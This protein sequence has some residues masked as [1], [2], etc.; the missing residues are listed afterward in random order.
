MK[1]QTIPIPAPLCGIRFIILTDGT[2]YENS[3]YECRKRL[4]ADEYAA[5]FN[6]ATTLLCNNVPK[7]NGTMAK[8]FAEAA[9]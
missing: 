2:V 9:Y 6:H 8:V 1:A 3:M 7:G 5:I 4:T